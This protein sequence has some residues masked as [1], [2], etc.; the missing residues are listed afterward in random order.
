M[1]KIIT[2]VFDTLF[3]PRTTELVVRE[4]TP[5]TMTRKYL[6]Q[7]HQNTICLSSYSDVQIKA[8]ITEN[9]YHQ[10]PAAAKYLANLLEQWLVTQTLP[11]V[12]IPI[13]LSKQREKERGYNQVMEVIKNIKATKTLSLNGALLQRT[14][15]TAPQTSLQRNERL[16]N[17][18]R[19]FVCDIEKVKSYENCILVL[20]DDVSTTGATLAA[21]RAA[22]QPNLHSTSK[23]ICVALAH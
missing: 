10:N 17:L 4:I 22:L 18:K 11:T 9:K 3:P 13:P 7:H 20:V 19:A 14:R 21:A 5:S 15:H 12:L 1:M 23:L 8:L 6:F 2:F 16:K